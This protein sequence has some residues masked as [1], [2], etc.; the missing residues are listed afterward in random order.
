M[1][2]RGYFSPSDANHN[3]REVIARA[4]FSKHLGIL[5]PVNIEMLVNL[6]EVHPELKEEGRRKNQH[7][8]VQAGEVCQMQIAPNGALDIGDFTRGPAKYPTSMVTYFPD[9]T[10]K[11]KE[12]EHFKFV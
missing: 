4:G 9:E 5:K 1:R 7:P 10:C 3:M 8:D 11:L 12:G 6:S 2:G